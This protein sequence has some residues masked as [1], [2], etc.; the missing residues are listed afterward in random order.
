MFSE[1]TVRFLEAA[2]AVGLDPEPTEYPEGTRT[3]ED[4][5]RAVGCEVSQIVKSLVFMADDE[6]VLVL[7]PGDLRVDTTKLAD[8]TGGAVRR[9]DLDEVRR[10]TGYVAGGTPPIGHSRPMTVYADGRLARHPT[11]WAA[12]GTPSTVFPIDVEDLMRV[13]AA[14]TADLA[15]PA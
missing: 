6:P 14:I 3:A 7:M 8:L 10:A 1:A 13:T 5:A 9:A 12:A 11:V 15:E 4:A 2:R